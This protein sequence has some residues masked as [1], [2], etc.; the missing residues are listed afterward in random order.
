MAESTLRAFLRKKNIQF[1][2][3]IILGSVFI[4]ASIGK[5]LHPNSFADSIS[6]YKILPVFLINLAAIIL[7]YGVTLILSVRTKISAI[8]LSL[9]LLIFISA[10]L[11]TI[12]RGLNIDCG[13]FA[14]SINETETYNV[15][16]WI[17]IL[18]DILLLIPGAIIIFFSK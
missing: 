6:N 9:L 16:L 15:D 3:Q 1:L 5:I 13:C 18:R 11:S 17:I 14:K 12:I 10:I 2:S 7:P 8:I 4:Y